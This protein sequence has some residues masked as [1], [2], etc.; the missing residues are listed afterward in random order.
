MQN[1]ITFLKI[2]SE[3]N[4]HPLE[5]GMVFYWAIKKAFQYSTVPDYIIAVIF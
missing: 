5:Y 1:I 3:F 2:K 4:E